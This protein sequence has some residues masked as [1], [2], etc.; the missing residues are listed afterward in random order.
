[1]NKILIGVIILILIGGGIFLFYPN[2][3]APATTS[4]DSNTETGVSDNSNTE[5]N[6]NQNPE[7]E[8]N[9][10][11]DSASTEKTFVLTGEN[12]K[13]MMDSVDNPELKVKQ[14]DKVRIEFTSTGGFH[15]WT[16]DEFNAATN[17]VNEGQSAFVEFVADKKGT[18]EYY[19][20][21]GSHRAN[22]MKGVFV[23][24]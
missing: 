1:M 10:N 11:P 15:D 21:V 9:S 3:D 13:F 8:T 6:T 7:E 24:E 16:L 14:G 22:G 12:F 4:G 17:K 20:S 19:C 23:V 18:F 5:S 2:S